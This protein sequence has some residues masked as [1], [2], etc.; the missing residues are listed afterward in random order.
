MSKREVN[1]HEVSLLK[2]RTSRKS[3]LFIYLMIMILIVVIAYIKLTGR[4]LNGYAVLIAIIFIIA[5][6]KGTEI[7]RLMNYY[8][9]FPAYIVHAQGFFKKDVKQ[10]HVPTISDLE[11][12]QSVWQRLLNFGTVEVYRYTQGTP[13]ILVKNINDPLSFIEVI[14]NRLHAMRGAD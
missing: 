11:L 2:V 12:K 1:P 7:H 4:P 3:Y 8:Q 14:E 5:A 10:I 13:N 9:I 6:I